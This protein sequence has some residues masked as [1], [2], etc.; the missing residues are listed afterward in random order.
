MAAAQL[1]HIP[2]YGW[3][4]DVDDPGRVLLLVERLE[5]HVVASLFLVLD[6]LVLV[7]SSLNHQGVGFLADFTLEGLPE[8]RAVVGRHLFLTLYFEP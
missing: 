3:S 5:H 6:Q 4:N 2:L 1:K 7:L 8:E